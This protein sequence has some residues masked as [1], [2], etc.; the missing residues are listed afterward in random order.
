MTGKGERKKKTWDKI[1]GIIENK[2]RID[3]EIVNRKKKKR[4]FIRVLDL[5]KQ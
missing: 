5:R 1:S 4:I 3:V 2:E